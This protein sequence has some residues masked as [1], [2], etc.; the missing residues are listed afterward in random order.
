MTVLGTEKFVTSIKLLE[1]FPVWEVLLFKVNTLQ[2][3]H[4]GHLLEGQSVDEVVRSLILIWFDAANKMKLAVFA[5]LYSSSG[6]LTTRWFRRIFHLFY[7]L[8]EFK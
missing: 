2:D 1:M 5:W 3:S 4:V 7:A 8:I 6:W